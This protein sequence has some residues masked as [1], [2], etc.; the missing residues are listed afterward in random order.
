MQVIC[1]CFMK[2][3]IYK[4]K[5]LDILEKNHLMSIEE[6][7][8]KIS[9]ADYS[10]IYRN[11]KK[12]LSEE[13]ILKRVFD[14]NTTLYEINSKKNQHGHFLCNICKKIEKIDMPKDKKLSSYEIQEY[15]LTG[16]CKECLKKK[17]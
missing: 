16:L 10:T 6:I 14:K 1:K 13:K 17:L 9:K 3:N 4:E 15:L 2:K 8:K 5:I 12:L 7:H 11:V